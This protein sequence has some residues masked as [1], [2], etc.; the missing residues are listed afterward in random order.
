[1]SEWRIKIPVQDR[2][3]PLIEVLTLGL[4]SE[5][6]DREDRVVLAR[7]VL[8]VGTEKGFQTVGDLL[9][10]VED[11]GP[12]ERRAIL[13][14]A[15]EGA[16]LTS[17]TD[18][19]ERRKVEVANESARLSAGEP[20]DSHGRAPVF[21]HAEG[22]TNFLPDPHMPGAFALTDAR[23]WCCPEHHSQGDFRPYTGARLA[24]S[25]S[26]SIID[27]DEQDAEIEQAK[28]EEAEREERAL[29]RA[30]QQEREA[31]ALRQVRERYVENAPPMSVLG[32]LVKRDGRIVQ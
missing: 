24:Y 31:E 28:R 22:C 2:D 25:P 17:A 11:A 3:Q 27:L 20:R 7:L 12:D 29:A 26:G 8:D 32:F 13:D 23:R 21:C 16:G 4:D 14:R 15:R 5:I 1:M 30:E 6:E 18:V 10:Y 9:D 19:E